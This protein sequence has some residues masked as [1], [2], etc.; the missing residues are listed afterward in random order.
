M[1]I[2]SFAIISLRWYENAVNED[3]KQGRL[4]M[5]DF[6]VII[7]TIPIEAADY[8]NSPDLLKAM[9]AVHLEDICAGELQ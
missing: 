6:S 1:M 3:L 2:I 4:R 8:S 9:M 5:E 7:P